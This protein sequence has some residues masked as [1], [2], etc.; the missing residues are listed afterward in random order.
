LI[1]H[2]GHEEY[3]GFYINVFVSFV[4]FEVIV[5]QS[6]FSLGSIP[7]L[8]RCMSKRFSMNLQ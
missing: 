1:H 4:L 6:Q 2:E 8:K 5:E 3:E 7:S